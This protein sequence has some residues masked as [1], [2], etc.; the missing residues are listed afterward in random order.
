MLGKLAIAGKNGQFRTPKHIEGKYR[1][2]RGV[3]VHPAFAA[4]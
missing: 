4:A 3:C 2:F 1:G